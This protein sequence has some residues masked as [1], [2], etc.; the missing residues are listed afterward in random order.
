MTFHI[1]E[2]V[3]NDPE[4]TCVI[5]ASLKSE[6]MGNTRFAH[7]YQVYQARLRERMLNRSASLVSFLPYV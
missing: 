3:A 6:T 5:I 7:W 1:L 2:D 4:S